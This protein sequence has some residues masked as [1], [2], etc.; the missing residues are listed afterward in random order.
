MM[1]G[2]IWQMAEQK[3]SWDRDRAIAEGLETGK[4][5]RALL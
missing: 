2:K 1:T 3:I 4:G 5:W